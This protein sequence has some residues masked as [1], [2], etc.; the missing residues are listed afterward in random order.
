MRFRVLAAAVALLGPPGLAAGTVDPGAASDARVSLDAREAAAADVIE[1]LARIGGFQTV[2]DPGPSC[3]LTLNV[4]QVPW[5]TAFETVLQACQLA[6]EEN[7]TVLRIAPRERLRA[8]SEDRR[9]LAEEQARTRTGSVAAFRLSYARAAEMAPILKR[10]LPGGD[11]I[12]DARTNT[13]LI[14]D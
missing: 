1:V 4:R 8:E 13:L 7:G 10:L 9:R 11:V 14:I 3:A 2:H 6:F 5:R 12:F